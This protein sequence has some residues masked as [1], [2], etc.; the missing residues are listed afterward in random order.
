MP[1]WFAAALRLA[2]VGGPVL[3]MPLMV[4]AGSLPSLS[5]SAPAKSYPSWPQRIA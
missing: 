4:M 1:W 2:G 3:S 5:R